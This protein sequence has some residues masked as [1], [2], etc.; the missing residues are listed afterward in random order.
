MIFGALVDKEKDYDPGNGLVHEEAMLTHKLR[1][2]ED[3]TTKYIQSS[4]PPSEERCK[5]LRE[6]IDLAEREVS[7]T[8]KRDL[9]DEYLRNYSPPVEHTDFLGWLKSQQ[10]PEGYSLSSKKTCS[11]SIKRA[12][13]LPS[14]QSVEKKM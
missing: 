9:Y 10:N 1:L 8:G 4:L 6:K 12:D 2:L 5:I 11:H 3:F 14:M 7:R 13:S